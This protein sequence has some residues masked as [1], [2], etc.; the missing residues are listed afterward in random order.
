MNR[1]ILA[2]PKKWQHS[3]RNPANASLDYSPVL[4]QT[5][6]VAGDSHLHL[7][8][9]RLPHFAKWTRG[10]DHGIQLTHMNKTISEGAGHLIVDLRN[11]V[12]CAFRGGERGIHPNSEA[13]E[14]MRVGG[15]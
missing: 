12:A 11:Y 2:I 9:G 14:A 3:I 7:G 13:A 5:G 6:D 15:R 4:N 8:D 10:T 1:E